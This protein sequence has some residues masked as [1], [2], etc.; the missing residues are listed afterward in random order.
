MTDWFNKQALHVK[1]AI[2][3]FVALFVVGL[4]VVPIVAIGALI[5]L[6]TV[7]SF[8]ILFFKLLNWLID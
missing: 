7:A 4:L 5:T 2:G 8:L 3:W 6:V 1:F